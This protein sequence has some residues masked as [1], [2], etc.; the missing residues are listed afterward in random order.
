MP[1]LHYNI[2]LFLHV[3]WFPIRTFYWIH[4]GPKSIDI[5][6]NC[7]GLKVLL[8]LCNSG[9][10]CQNTVDIEHNIEEQR[11]LTCNIYAINS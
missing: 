9:G 5:T 7:P 4:I 2:I 11:L 10:T 1:G 8:V 3:Y 6:H